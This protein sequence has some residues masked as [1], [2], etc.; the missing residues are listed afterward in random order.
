MKITKIEISDFRSIKSP[1][2]IGFRDNKPTVFIGKNGSGKTNILEALYYIHYVNTERNGR[3]P[4]S[5]KFKYKIFIKLSEK[6]LKSIL[7]EAVYDKEKSVIVAYCDG[8]NGLAIDAV[9]SDYLIPQIKDEIN[10]LEALVSSL[11]VKMS[12]YE[13]L[14]T[15]EFGEYGEKTYYG[16]V[17]RHVYTEFAYCNLG[18]LYTTLNEAQKALDE[19]KEEYDF[20][21]DILRNLNNRVCFY[22]ERVRPVQIEYR[23]HSLAPFEQRHVTIDEE[24]LKAAVCELNLKLKAEQDAINADIAEI[25]DRVKRLTAIADDQDERKWNDTQRYSGFLGRVKKLIGQRCSFLRN[26]NDDVIFGEKNQ[27]DSYHGHKNTKAIIE[28][29]LRNVYKGPDRREKL[30]DLRSNKSIRL[31][32]G[33]RAAFEDYINS[34]LPNYE[35][36]ILGVSV[37]DGG[38]TIYIKEQTG[39]LVDLNS[40]S[41]G[42]RWYFTY[43]FMKNT[44]SKGHVFIIDE[45]AAALHPKAQKEILR[46]IEELAKKGVRVFYSTHSPYLIPEDWSC[47]SFVTMKGGTGLY[48]PDSK[49]EL[50]SLLKECISGDAPTDIFEL[51]E[52]YEQ[53]MCSDS[54]MVSSF[55][56][57]KIREKG[58]YKDAARALGIS[59][60][61]IKHWRAKPSPS[62]ENLIKLSIYLEIPLKELLAARV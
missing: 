16:L 36:D 25:V 14:L 18:E 35:T 52:L 9:W 12:R 41:L 45:P 44:L 54:E 1:V 23:A 24:G 28:T 60:D 15:S 3:Y 6:D 56:K 33:E 22:R 50:F 21:L 55:V 10:A 43:Y 31:T 46:D 61:A 8:Q 47:V 2:T 4:Y 49:K 58:T 37:A 30:S 57:D 53:Y 7:P 27:G 26:D 40:T 39:E 38:D 19:I 32:E 48:E 51:Q 5:T 42:R 11:R 17:C 20:T 62:F 34:N 29:Y 59:E 13:S